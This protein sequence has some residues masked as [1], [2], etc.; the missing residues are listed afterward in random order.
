MARKDCPTGAPST[1]T[2][3]PSPQ[4]QPEHLLDAQEIAERAVALVDSERAAGRLLSILD[5]VRRVIDSLRSSHDRHGMGMLGAHDRGILASQTHRDRRRA[6]HRRAGAGTSPGGP[7][8]AAQM[9][10]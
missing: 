1:A 7:R 8:D 6:D 3:Q 10:L 5:A 4:E 2:D 9:T